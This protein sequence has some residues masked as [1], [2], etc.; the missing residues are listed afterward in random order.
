[1]TTYYAKLSFIRLIRHDTYKYVK[2]LSIKLN[3]YNKLKVYS[4]LQY[5]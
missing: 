1:M 4:L 5:I 2:K 3:I